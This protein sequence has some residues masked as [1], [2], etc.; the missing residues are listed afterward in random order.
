MKKLGKFPDSAY[1]TFKCLQKGLNRMKKKIV[2]QLI[3]RQDNYITV[4]TMLH[5]LN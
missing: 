4:E 1:L 2:L 5:K 3:F